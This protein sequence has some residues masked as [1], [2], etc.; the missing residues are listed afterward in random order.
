[1][2]ESNLVAGR[3]DLDQQHPD[4]LEYGK[5]VTDACVDLDM[6]AAM[7][8]E[9]ADA[10]RARRGR[11]DRPGAAPPARSLRP[12]RVCSTISN[13]V[14]L[15]GHAHRTQNHLRDHTHGDQADDRICTVTKA[16]QLCPRVMSPYPTVAN[17][18]TVK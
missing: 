4:A 1:M 3:Q 7:L 2:L 16:G 13:C 10:A 5:S 17:V 6:T 18:V 12:S 11:P 9:L 15:P 14:P 8:D